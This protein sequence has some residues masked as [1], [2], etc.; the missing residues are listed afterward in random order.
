VGGLSLSLDLIVELLEV[1]ICLDP[2]RPVNENLRLISGIRIPG[3]ELNMD[4]R[5]NL[6]HSCEESSLIFP[7][8]ER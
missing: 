3:R 2:G 8:M 4:V 7:L 6:S 5:L 1:E